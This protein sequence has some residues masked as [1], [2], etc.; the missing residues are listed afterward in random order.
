MLSADDLH[1]GKNEL[2]AQCQD[3]NIGSS[4]AVFKVCRNS[5]NFFAMC[6]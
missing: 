1:V 5:F 2:V 4:A 3:I 6:N